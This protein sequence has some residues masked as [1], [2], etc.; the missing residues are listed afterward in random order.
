MFLRRE[1]A[2]KT[3]LAGLMLAGA[4]GMRHIPVLAPFADA[5]EAAASVFLG[6]VAVDRIRTPRAP[7]PPPPERRPLG[8]P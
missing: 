5:A 7:D 4:V 6:L 8:M 3:T 2:W 1:R